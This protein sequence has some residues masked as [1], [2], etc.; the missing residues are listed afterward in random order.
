M[1]PSRLTLGGENF[2]GWAGQDFDIGF[3]AWVV[4]GV[5]SI[6]VYSVLRTLTE[7]P[8]HPWRLPGWGPGWSL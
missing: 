8:R 1:V 5:W 2:V 6:E 3:K 4:D 7:D